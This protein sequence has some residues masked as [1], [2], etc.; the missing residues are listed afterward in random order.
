MTDDPPDNVIARIERDAR[1]HTA[2][3]CKTPVQEDT[4]LSSV[5]KRIRWA[6]EQAGLSQEKLGDLVGRSQVWIFQMERAEKT[7]YELE[8]L[9]RLAK[10]SHVNPAWLAFGEPY[11][12]DGLD[13]APG[14]DTWPVV[15]DRPHPREYPIFAGMY[16]KKSPKEE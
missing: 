10:A 12:P 15:D 3:K 14:L 1:G 13:I 7:R 8:F 2:R 16:E 11:A 9:E 6:R 5:P 4:D